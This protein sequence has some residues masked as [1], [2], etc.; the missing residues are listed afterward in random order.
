MLGLRCCEGLSLP[1]ERGDYSLV[2]VEGLLI[3]A[4]PTVVEPGL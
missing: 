3:E 2:V 1:A 4:A